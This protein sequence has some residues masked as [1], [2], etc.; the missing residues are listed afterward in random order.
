MTSTARFLKA[1]AVAPLLAGLGSVPATALQRS[2][3]VNCG[4][5]RCSDTWDVI[6]PGSARMD[7]RVRDGSGTGD[8]L[9]VTLVASGPNA[10]KG[11][12]ES[13]VADGLPSPGSFSG[14]AQIFADKASTIRAFAVVTSISTVDDEFAFYV[15][16][17]T[18]LNSTG[19]PVEPTKMELLQGQ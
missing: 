1:L 13:E 12:T 10:L 5:T 9:A 18:C 7:A 8:T 16:E 14:R 3:G 11:Q 2:E 15:L 19:T 4:F 6:C 17:V